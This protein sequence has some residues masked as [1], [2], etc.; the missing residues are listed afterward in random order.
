MGTHPIF[1]SDFD[2]LT[3]RLS[4]VIK[5]GPECYTD[6]K[7]NVFFLP[8]GSNSFTTVMS[9]RT[10]PV[11]NVKSVNARRR[12]TWKKSYKTSQ[13]RL[14]GDYA[15]LKE[16][17]EACAWIHHQAVSLQLGPDTKALAYALFDRAIFTM[18]V[19]RTHCAVLAAA[20]VLISTKLLEDEICRDLGKFLIR[21]ANLTFS[22]R[23]LIRME[24]LLLQKF[25]WKIDDATSIDM[26][27][28]LFELSSGPGRSGPGYQQKNLVAH[29]LASELVNLELAHIPC[30]ELALAA[31]TAF[32]YKD[33]FTL[34]GQLKM[35]KISFS[36]SLL[37]EAITYLR[38][39]FK[40]LRVPSTVLNADQEDV[41]PLLSKLFSHGCL[42]AT[43]FGRKSIADVCSSSAM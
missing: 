23:D 5:N 19:K 29:F 15:G 21:Q 14:S 27:F 12:E 1:E 18:K 41:T 25:D 6:N 17:N 2:C 34:L 20:S 16:R 40:K 39:R 10:K 43:S 11:Q 13:A 4:F 42:E 8:S 9:G 24:M 36:R 26:L 35:N 7:F 28:A 3:E 30:L 31:L 38:P 37:N 33:S 32:N 22:K